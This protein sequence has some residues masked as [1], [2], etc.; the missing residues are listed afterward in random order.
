MYK[1]RFYETYIFMLSLAP[2]DKKKEFPVQNCKFNEKIFFV[3]FY[4]IFLPEPLFL[5][6]LTYFNL[7]QL[8]FEHGS[9]VLQKSYHWEIKTNQL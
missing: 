7:F 8:L 6:Q 1:E 9:I 3:S 4:P 2:E 5:R